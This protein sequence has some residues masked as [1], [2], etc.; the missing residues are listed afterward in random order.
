[1]GSSV[2]DWLE[3]HGLG[4]SVD[5]AGDN[6][7]RRRPKP[8]LEAACYSEECA[9]DPKAKRSVVKDAPR[10]A[11]FCADCGSALFWRPVRGKG[12]PYKP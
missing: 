1:M 6:Q 4:A 7:A 5:E 12:R 9:H 10:T 2:F 8:P 11:V 3:R